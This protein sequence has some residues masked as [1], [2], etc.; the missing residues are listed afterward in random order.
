VLSQDEASSAAA[1]YAVHVA[2][3]GGYASRL[4]LINW[5]PISQ[6][7]Q[8]TFNGKTVTRTIPVHGRLDESIDQLFTLAPNA[9]VTDSLKLQ[10][11]SSI[12]GVTGFVEISAAG[13]RLLTAEYFSHEAEIQHVFSH[14]A[15]GLGYFTGL[16]LY[17]PEA[18]AATA[19]IEVLSTTGATLSSNA[20]TIGPNQRVVGLLSD[21]AP[22]ISNQF[23][24]LVRVTSTGAIYTFEVVSGLEQGSN[25]IANIPVSIY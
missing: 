4:K 2:S 13:G 18:S 25:F 7:I 23:G 11:T 1:L 5:S 3:G 16:V 17:N 12:P 20:V 9:N 8:L 6:Q 22:G 15:Q 19:T 10:T 14:V 21:F 24:G